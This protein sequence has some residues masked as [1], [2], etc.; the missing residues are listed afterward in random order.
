M[1]TKDFKLLERCFEAGF[2]SALVEGWPNLAQ[3]KSARMPELQKAGLVEFAELKLPGR[4]VVV[5]K[6]WRLTERGHF[7]YCAECARRMD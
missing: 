2:K 7:E 3:I 6:G 5:V 1:T 4:F